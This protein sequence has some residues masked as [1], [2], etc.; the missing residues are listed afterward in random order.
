MD[1]NKTLLKQI[2]SVIDTT[3]TAIN[4]LSISCERYSIKYDNYVKNNPEYMDTDILKER[5]KDA[6]IKVINDDIR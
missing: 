6:V 1:E 5:L 3:Q 2:Q 4:E